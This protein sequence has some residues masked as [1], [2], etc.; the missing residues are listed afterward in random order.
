VLRAFTTASAEPHP[1]LVAAAGLATQHRLRA[2]AHRV[3]CDRGADDHVVAAAAR[4]VN[5]TDTACAAL[6]D[7]IDLWAAAAL[8]EHRTAAAHTE[9]LGQVVN[10]LASG[11]VR[12]HVLA[13]HDGRTAGRERVREAFRRLGELSVGYDDLIIDLASGRRRLPRGQALTGPAAA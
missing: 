4:A 12:C 10:R 7:Q 8:P 11:W 5:A 13:A 9:T 1:L 3:V 6:I 2:Q